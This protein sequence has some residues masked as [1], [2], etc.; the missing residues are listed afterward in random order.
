MEAVADH[1]L[2]RAAL[3]TI[4]VAI[5]KTNPA[6]YA[7]KWNSPD[8]WPYEWRF[9]VIHR[10]RRRKLQVVVDQ[11]DI[12]VGGR[13]R[14]ELANPR[15]GELVAEHVRQFFGKLTVGIKQC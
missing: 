5:K 11:G 15:V 14:Y 1:T 9:S 2:V 12:V 13:T 10:D 8:D 6:K 7:F 3:T 4:A